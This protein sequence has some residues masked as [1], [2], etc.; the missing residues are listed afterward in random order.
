MEEGR[1][2][3][4]GNDAYTNYGL[5][6]AQGTYA[7]LLTL[8]KKKPV[9]VKDW[10]DQNGTQRMLPV[11]PFFESITYTIPVYHYGVNEADF[12]TKYAA[13]GAFIQ[14]TNYFT[15]DVVEMNRRFV[16]LYDSMPSFDKLTLIRG[17]DKVYCKST[18]SLI[19]DYPVTVTNIATASVDLQMDLS[20]T[21]PTPPLYTFSLSDRG[22]LIM[23][24]V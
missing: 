7:E 20:V 1:Y 10:G 24:T 23:E 3:I 19:N 17:G 14:S 16:L 2:F 11:T 12:Y 18:L 5:V 22:E 8:P 6:F 4:N 21:T 13:W 9:L 15:F